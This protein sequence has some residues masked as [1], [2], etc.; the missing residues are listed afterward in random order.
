VPGHSALLAANRAD[1]LVLEIFG[2]DIKSQAA[3]LAQ[4][5]DLRKRHSFVWCVPHKRTLKQ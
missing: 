4:L 3:Y 5:S 1:Q 2:T